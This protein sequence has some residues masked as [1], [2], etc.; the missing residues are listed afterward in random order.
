MFGC[1]PF[2]PR[3]T[4]MLCAGACVLKTVPSSTTMLFKTSAE[5]TNALT[6]VSPSLELTT[7]DS[8]F[9]ILIVQP[10]FSVFLRTDT[11][12]F[13]FFQKAS[14]PIL[15]KRR[16]LLLNRFWYYNYTH[17]IFGYAT[18][19]GPRQRITFVQQVRLIK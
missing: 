8:S 1:V 11:R 14:P 18:S 10:L 15:T 13:P 9:S 17:N 19:P 5:G 16:V 6:L 12:R 2:V 7:L 3:K 4:L